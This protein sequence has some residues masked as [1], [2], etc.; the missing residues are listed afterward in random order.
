MGP[1][2]MGRSSRVGSVVAAVAIVVGG[3]AGPPGPVGGPSPSPSA[4]T[5]LTPTGPPR[6]PPERLTDLV[7]YDRRRPLGVTTRGATNRP[8]DGVVVTDL[9]Y[10]GGFGQPVEA[11]LVAPLRPPVRRLAGVVFAHGAGRDRT[12]FLAEATILARRGAL[13]LLP[14]VPMNMSGN[15]GDDITTIGRS[16]IAQRRAVDVLVARPEV[17]RRR[18]GFAGHSW[19]AVLG[20]VLAGSEP[21]LAAVV[22]ASFTKPVS[23]YFGA[24]KQYRDE[25]S[26]FDQHRWLALRGNR[27]VLLQAGRLDGWHPADATDDLYTAIADPKER[28][29][30]QLGHDLVE[31]AEP[32]NDRREFLTRVLRLD[33]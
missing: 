31:P 21:R 14:T 29:D 20:A 15:A 10:D 27:R 12:R 7:A 2:R 25:I 19:G 24:T 8:K 22:L 16:V 11:Y 1:V 13:V 3:C 30:Y 23:K 9:T 33:R 18:L 26:V 17:D 4:A 28:K 32:V 6:V 5:T